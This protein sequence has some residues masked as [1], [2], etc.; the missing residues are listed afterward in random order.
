MRKQLDYGQ[1]QREYELLLS[2]LSESNKYYCRDLALT[3]L[4]LRYT[5]G[6]V[7]GLRRFPK[8]LVHDFSE[9][10][11]FNRSYLSKQM[12]VLFDRYNSFPTERE[13]VDNLMSK[14][15]HKTVQN[16]YVSGEAI[17]E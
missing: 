14:A 12:R 7:S 17:D 2:C 11:G 16:S 13:K 4:M 1:L 5:N 9:A 10:L 15:F 3:A 8:G 6:G